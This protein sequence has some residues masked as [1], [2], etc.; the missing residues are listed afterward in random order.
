[1][2]YNAYSHKLSKSRKDT[3]SYLNVMVVGSVGSGKTA[4]VRTFCETLKHDVIQGT[5]KESK[6][7]VLKDP[8]RSTDELYTVSM[9]IEENGQ[10]T[11]L[12]IIDTPGF[13]S[14][15][16]IDHQL[17]YIAKYIDYQFERTLAEES[18]VKR[19]AKALDTHIHSCLYFIDIKNMPAMSEADKYILKMLS[20]RVNI[21]PVIGKSDTLTVAQREQI[22]SVFRREIFDILRIPIYGCIDVEEEYT[23]T[24]AVD[25]QLPQHLNRML[26]M[27][28]ECV[29]EDKDEDAD[30]L[31]DYL[32]SMPFTLVGYEEDPETGRPLN[33]ANTVTNRFIES[34]EDEE[35]ASPVTP[36]KTAG[37]LNNKN[38]LGR[39][40]PWAV[41]EC[42]NPTHCDF[43]QLKNTLLSSHR[44]MLRID[45]FE[46]FYEQY[47]TEQL[48]N[49]KV[50][51]MIR[52]DSKQG[53]PLI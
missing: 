48:M 35:M 10:R 22:K 52:L 2:L 42:C 15:H 45:T 6:P 31:I 1:M 44:D 24:S 51:R 12:T 14:G 5:L 49:R 28:Q 46:R 37:R 18:K 53:V 16:A 3:L 9:H 25:K 38:V 39:R 4:F 26:S 40:Y 8:L 36:K 29:E 41:V 50:K 23:T 32:H 19:D 33:L 7:M 20:S 43:S 34:A 21:I 47:R 11:A 13:T 30:A 27:L 17:R